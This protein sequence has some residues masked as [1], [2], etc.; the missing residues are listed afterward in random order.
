MTRRFGADIIADGMLGSDLTGHRVL[1]TGIRDWRRDSL[2]LRGGGVAV[3]GA[4]RQV[5]APAPRYSSACTHSGS[6]KGSYRLTQLMNSNHDHSTMADTVTVAAIEAA[7][8]P[9]S[10]RSLVERF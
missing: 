8:L 4:F 3:A 5:N 7:A 9:G 6:G 2:R 10:T 1:V